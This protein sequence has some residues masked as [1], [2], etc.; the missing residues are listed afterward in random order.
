[1][2]LVIKASGDKELFSE[3]KLASSIRRAGIP[4]DLQK[5]VANH[6]RGKLYDGIK[7]SEIYNHIVEFLER[8]EYPYAKTRYSLKQAI[9]TL[10]PSGY[11][12]EDYLAKVFT[13]EGY[14][15][16][17][18]QILQG[19]CVTHEIDVVLE[20]QGTRAIV[21]AK[22]H[23]TPGIKTTIHVSL[24]T[25]A[26]F[27]D[28]KE[29]NNIAQAWLVSNTSVT[30][31]AISYAQCVGMKI[32]SWNYPNENSLRELIEKHRLFPIT[33]LTT[34]SLQH[35]QQLLNNH[36]VLCKQICENES[37]LDSLS[38]PEEQKKQIHKEAAFVCQSSS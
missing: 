18:R 31:D 23:N 24:Y 5:T 6:V 29:K 11:P 34:V 20:K 32:M 19:T 25:K 22:Y 14:Q 21:E 2:T 3:E 16:Q 30:V 27:D 12:F 35:K 1:M 13:A 17:V 37:L 33:A 4:E 26:R 7:T 36:V 38:L 8:S 15:T 28:V 10:G 9:M